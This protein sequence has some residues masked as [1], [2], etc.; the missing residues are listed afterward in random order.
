MDYTGFTRAAEKLKRLK[1][2]KGKTN[3]NV[4]KVRTYVCT[5]NYVHDDSYVW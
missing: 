1:A 3:L 4:N 5:Y 2:P